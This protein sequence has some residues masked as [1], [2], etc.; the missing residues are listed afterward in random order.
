MLRTLL[1]SP[2]LSLPGQTARSSHTGVSLVLGTGLV[3]LVLGAAL[4]P[5]RGNAAPIN[6][7]GLDALTKPD[8]TRLIKPPIRPRRPLRPYFQDLDGYGPARSYG[9]MEVAYVRC[10]IARPGD[11]RR[12]VLSLKAG[13]RLILHSD[14]K[15][16]QDT[17]FIDRPITVSGEVNAELSSP[18]ARFE[19]LKDAALPISY[20]LKPPKDR[21]CI[22]VK[23]VKNVSLKD[24]AID[25]SEA[26]NAACLRLEEAEVTL[27]RT[28]IKYAGDEPAIQADRTDLTFDQVLISAETYVSAV[29]VDHA[30][31]IGRDFVITGAPIGI[32]L[33]PTGESASVIDNAILLGAKTPS[34]F[35]PSSTGLV[36]RGL[37]EAGRVEVRGATLCGFGTGVW[38]DGANLVTLDDTRICRAAKGVAVMG[39]ELNLSRSAIGAYAYGLH[40]G[41]GRAV[42]R[43]SD[44]YG[45]PI[46][47]FQLEPGAAPV[48][49][50]DNYFYTD[51]GECA[52]VEVKQDTNRRIEPQDRLWTYPNPS[53]GICRSPT[54]APSA[55]ERAERLLADGLG[56]RWYPGPSPMPQ[57]RMYNPYYDNKPKSGGFFGFGQSNPSSSYP[58]GSYPGGSYPGGSYP[59][60]GGYG[61][62]QPP[63]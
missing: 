51:K 61:G 26:G 25:A 45:N 4:S 18:V 17:L 32:D 1:S 11:V 5:T 8:F 7:A 22:I 33:T 59:Q 54:S 53:T 39:G 56:L 63:R 10:D 6:E 36:V 58:N 48:A 35:G 28:S 14:G 31:F 52:L 2:G 40:I 12:A 3:C 46:R 30:T 49:G 19:R 27:S 62:G 13:G 44:F 43:S 38:M 55:S 15:P 21:P 9:R 42:A 16:C 24:L 23:G 60:G 37:R 20:V 34:G 50:G 41:A 47:A 29:S 57:G